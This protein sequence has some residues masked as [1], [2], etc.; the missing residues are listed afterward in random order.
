[1]DETLTIVAGTEDILISKDLC[2][3][4]NVIPLHIPLL[5][6]RKKD[7]L[8]IKDLDWKTKTRGL[9]ASGYIIV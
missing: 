3:R 8:K 5:R 7:M 4:L 9:F 6:V 1:M 2:Y